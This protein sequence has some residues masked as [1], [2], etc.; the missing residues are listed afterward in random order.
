METKSTREQLIDAGL[1]LIHQNGYIATGLKEILDAAGVPKG[2]FY[3]HFS[4]KEEF[5]KAVL[6]KYAARE[7]NR[8]E[9]SGTAERRI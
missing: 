6:E 3:H 5:A 1:R 7:V 8:R 4:S 9:A 2:S